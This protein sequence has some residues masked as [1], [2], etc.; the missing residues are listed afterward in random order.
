MYKIKECNRLILLSPYG[1]KLHKSWLS[2]L[3][4][5]SLKYDKDET[6]KL[7]EKLS[8]E[9]DWNSLMEII[10]NIEKDGFKFSLESNTLS[11]VAKISDSCDRT[12]LISSLRNTDEVNKKMIVWELI[13]DFIT[14]IKNTNK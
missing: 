3:N 13:V 9:K 5:F 14:Y 10:S 8:Y 1:T 12:L 2:K 11:Y 7:Y 6:D 4:E